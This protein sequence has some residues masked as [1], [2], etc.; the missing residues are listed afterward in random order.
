MDTANQDTT[1][2]LEV[3]QNPIFS[4][5]SDEELKVKSDYSSL[6]TLYFVNTYP[7]LSI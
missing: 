7:N 4:Q 6:S 5:T 2:N 3:C 1:R